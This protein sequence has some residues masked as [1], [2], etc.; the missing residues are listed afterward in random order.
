MSL[1]EFAIANQQRIRD[2]LH[3][4]EQICGNLELQSE[5][6]YNDCIHYVSPLALLVNDEF[7]SDDDGHHLA[8]V[9]S[10]YQMGG[11]ALAWHDVGNPD[12][13]QFKS[14]TYCSTPMFDERWQKLQEHGCCVP[15][16]C[17]GEDAV[18]VLHEN[19]YCY[20]SYATNY[21]RIFRD[22]K[23][24]GKFHVTDICEPLQ[25]DLSSPG[26][27]IVILIILTFAAC[28]TAAS[29]RTQYL[30]ELN[31]VKQERAD[32]VYGAHWFLFCFSIQHLWKTFTARRPADKSQLNFLDGIR[33]FSMLWV[34]YGHSF[35]F[36][37]T[38]HDG[39]P[40]NKA[41]F[42]LP[43]SR[44]QPHDHLSVLTQFYM[45]FAEYAPFSV[46]SFLYLSGFL[47]AFA[48]YRQLEKY[49]VDRNGRSKA[50]RQCY[51]WIPMAYINR[52]LRLLPMMAFVLLLEWFVADQLPYS[53]RLTLR[54]RYAQ[55]CSA[56]WY[57]AM[58]FYGNLKRTR[59]VCMDH[60]WYIQCDMQLFLLLPVLVLLFKWRRQVGL[61][62]SVLLIAAGIALRIYFA[63]NYHF[64]ANIIAND[65]KVAEQNVQY[66]KPWNRMTPYVVGVLTMFITIT[67]QDK[68]F[69]IQRR[70]VYF[71]MMTLS[72][73]TLCCLVMWPYDDVKEAPEHRWSSTANQAYYV[74]SQPAWGAAL[75]LLS[76]A[77]VFK[78]KH[79]QSLTNTLLSADIYQPVGK[80][81]YTMYLMH[82]LMLQ[83]FF[84]DLNMSTYYQYWWLLSVF[85][86]ISMLTMLVAF[87][88]W[89]LIEQPTAN[90]ITLMMKRL[91]SKCSERGGSKHDP[92]GQK[93]DDLELAPLTTNNEN[94][95]IAES[96]MEMIHDDEDARDVKARR[97]RDDLIQSHIRQLT[98][99]QKT[100]DVGLR[101]Q[102]MAK[103]SQLKRRKR[104]KVMMS[105]NNQSALTQTH[106]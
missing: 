106:E 50:I 42:Q 36:F 28:I 25:R 92:K 31:A 94:H 68:K 73:F 49:G 69:E 55:Q 48:V 57:T 24:R 46:D 54:D 86:V 72:L 3:Q 15:G 29:I 12:M 98:Q 61:G 13:C 19:A 14:G 26:F 52:L 66:Y 70:S 95:E 41:V 43:S 18:K 10:W 32:N 6:C 38:S 37:M 40:S 102:S 17:Q 62:A 71:C 21:R 1:R 34:I 77:I 90:M 35:V 81:T 78:G 82:W 65:K 103:T 2:E 104:V 11:G 58:F 39:P 100:A 89:F 47:G 9:M 105:Q 33:V 56:T 45:I 97:D 44:A 63:V 53:Y 101:K 59:N 22:M 8:K 91:V 96:E 85:A 87:L 75:G 51:T 93:K 5:Q 20:Q 30:L 7:F 27:W 64:L 99:T 76:F 79:I 67:F 23:F 16:S 80:L 4:N 74:L 60:L 83:W 84:A 88:L